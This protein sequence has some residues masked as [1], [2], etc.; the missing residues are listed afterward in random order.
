M[1]KQELNAAVKKLMTDTRTSASLKMRFLSNAIAYLRLQESKIPFA[2]DGRFIYYNP[3][4]ISSIMLQLGKGSLVRETLDYMVLHITVHCLFRHIF[5]N[6]KFPPEM[7]DIA[8]DIFAYH[9]LLS[10]EEDANSKSKKQIIPDTPLKSAEVQIVQDIRDASKMHS[11]STIIKWLVAHPDVVDQIT[12][13]G[14]F[15]VDDHTIWH[16]DSKASSKGG[17]S[18]QKNKSNKNNKSGKKSDKKKDDQKDN[19]EDQS[20]DKQ[21]K[22]SRRNQRNNESDDNEDDSDNNSDNEDGSN[23][24]DDSDNEDNNSNSEDDSNSENSPDND[25]DSDGSDNDNDN[26][27]NGDDSNDDSSGDDS[28]DSD[29]SGDNSSSDIESSSVSQEELD[30]IWK[31][32]ASL[33]KTGLETGLTGGDGA[34]NALKGLGEVTR[35]SFSYE[36]FLRKFS[37]ITEQMEINMDEFDYCYYTYGLNLYGNIP[38][39]EPL[40]YKDTKRIH[41]FVVAIDTSGSTYGPLV[42]KFLTKTFNILAEQNSFD[43]RV[44]I[45]IIQC[46]TRIQ[47]DCKIEDTKDLEEYMRNFS[48]YGGGGTDFRPVFTYVEELKKAGE[49]TDLRGLIY[50]T[51]GYGDFPTQIPD[52]ETA[53]AFVGDDHCPLERVPDWAISLILDEESLEVTSNEY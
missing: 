31:H 15:A 32:M 19:E 9:I 43:S 6:K 45:H 20:E 38:L 7:W 28:D 34:G 14:L 16:L 11:P 44:C 37:V 26:D 22:Q 25:D 46:D 10:V 30:R 21:D 12:S 41:D 53:F 47:H 5:V 23:S 1:N 36:D 27:S 18:D 29:G 39:I 35:E 49:F 42:Q 3:E 2:V 13:L 8:C 4:Y 52:Y 40:E 48:I 33:A 51:D 50:F 17:K 24:E